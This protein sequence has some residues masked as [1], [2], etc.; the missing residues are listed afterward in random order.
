M[1]KLLIALLLI[2]VIA[3]ANISSTKT[4]HSERWY[5]DNYCPGQVEVR[6]KDNANPSHN[7]PRVDCI[8]NT[9]A[10]EFDFAHKWAEAIGQSLYYASQT[11]LKPGIYLIIEDDLKDQKYVER[12]FAALR[13]AKLLNTVDV[14]LV[15]ADPDHS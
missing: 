15:M 2:P 4:H 5:Q 3:L 12:L 11:K 7:G 13:E 6:L 1:K 8:T 14:W 9:H 10:I